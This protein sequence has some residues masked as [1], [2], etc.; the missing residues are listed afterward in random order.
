MSD[1]RVERLAAT[2]RQL[3]RRLDGFE[4]DPPTDPDGVARWEIDLYAYDEALV[5][6]ADVLDVEVQPAAREDLAPAH[7]AE[8][9]AG[10][11]G[12]GIDVRRRS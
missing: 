5:A 1:D 4:A 10:L 8:I 11:A 12:A 2:L 7:R 6:A 9:E 3:R